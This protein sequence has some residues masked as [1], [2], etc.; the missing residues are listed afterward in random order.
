MTQL[1]KDRFFSMAEAYDQTASYLVPQ[2]D[3]MQDELV[4]L[5]PLKT[6]RPVTIVD[7]GA[8]SGRLLEKVLRA[9]YRATCVHIDYSEDFQAV[10]KR[11]LAPYGQRVRFV[12]ASFEDAWE[13][14]LPGPVDAIVS[15]SAIHHLDT[16]GKKALYR[17]CFETLQS[18]G[19]FFNVDEMKGFSEEAYRNSL[20]F[21]VRWVEQAR[22]CLPDEQR[23]NFDR[24][25]SHFDKW[26]VRNVDNIDKP[27]VKGDD[28]HEGFVD[29]AHWLCEAGFAE[30]DVFFKYQLWSAV[31]GHRPPS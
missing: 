7:L 23:P 30:V 5:L 3:W 17:R 26:K 12:L 14:Q 2:Y 4:R 20:H 28:I 22:D 27:K 29:Q 25:R 21:W 18:G 9:D 19:W 8:G 16:Q 6:G 31:G 15:M 11:R 10:A 1:D 13:S 24:W